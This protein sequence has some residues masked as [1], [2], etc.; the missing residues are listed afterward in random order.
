M[1]KKDGGLAQAAITNYHA[2]GDLSNRNLLFF[3]DFWR[4][5]SP[6]PRC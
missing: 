1:L 5:G 4:L 6:R 3:L 2:S